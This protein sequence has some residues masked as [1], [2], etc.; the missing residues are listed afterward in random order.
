MTRQAAVWAEKLPLAKRH[1]VDSSATAASLACVPRTY[2]DELSTA[3][4]GFVGQHLNESVPRS[5]RNGISKAMIPN[6]IGYSQI[7]NSNAAEV[8]SELA[9][10][11]V[12]EVEPLV[13][14]FVVSPCELEPCFAS[15][16]A[17]LL[18][19][20][21]PSV[22]QLQPLLSLDQETRIAYNLTIGKGGEA[23]KPNINA[24][25][26]SGRVLNLNVRHF[27]GEDGKPL[28]RLVLLDGEGFDFAFWNTMQDDWDAADFGTMQS[29]VAQKLESALR[30]NDAAHSAFESWKAFFLAELVFD[31]A[32]EAL[33][34]F[35]NPFSNIF[36]DLRMNLR[37]LSRKIVVEVKLPQRLISFFIGFNI[38]IKKFII[39]SFTNLERINQ[40]FLLLTRRVNSVTIHQ[41]AHNEVIL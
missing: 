11:L 19:S 33:E 18:L 12:Q 9:G 21:Q 13:G 30:V 20:V 1:F 2:L 34:G 26:L 27:A 39:N 8:G 22:K 38:Q 7:L 10:Q 35:R 25:L 5:V 4:Y 41:Q 24:D 14:D 3:S 16:S 32:K 15:V 40:P 36:S 23:F 37:I 31:S 28:P 6:H 17:A 29:F